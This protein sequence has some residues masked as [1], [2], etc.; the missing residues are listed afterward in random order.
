M[1]GGIFYYFVCVCSDGEVKELYGR[2]RKPAQ[3][4]YKGE[5]IRFIRCECD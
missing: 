3:G 2:V 5:E 1:Y 4:I